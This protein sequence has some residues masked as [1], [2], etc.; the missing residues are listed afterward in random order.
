MGFDGLFFGRADYQD[1]STRNATKTKEM[2]WKA[3]GSLGN[4]L[5]TD[6]NLISIEHSIHRVCTFILGTNSYLF[7]GILPHGYGVPGGFCFDMKCADQP[8]M[9]SKIFFSFYIFWHY[10]NYSYQLFIITIS[11]IREGRIAVMQSSNGQISDPVKF[12]VGSYYDNY[13]TL[14]FFIVDTDVD[15]P[16][17]H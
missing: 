14:L 11:L 10:K 1:I 6:Y 12:T 5:V 17:F 4:L 3:S 13:S 9:V 16:L 7:T 15:I 2:V 8:I